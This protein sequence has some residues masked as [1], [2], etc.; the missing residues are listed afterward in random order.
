MTEREILLCLSLILYLTV[1]SR[2]K[3]VPVLVRDS[4]SLWG[5]IR[6]IRTYRLDETQNPMVTSEL[7]QQQ[8]ITALVNNWW[9][10]HYLFLRTITS[11]LVLVVLVVQITVR[12]EIENKKKGKG[13]DDDDDTES[14][15]VVVGLV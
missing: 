10:Q 5:L 8:K 11:R 15:W 7:W 2:E 9:Y 13:D 4:D 6:W 1:K 3:I 14:C 12:E